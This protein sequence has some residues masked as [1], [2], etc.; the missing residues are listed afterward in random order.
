MNGRFYRSDTLSGSPDVVLIDA[1]SRA[2]SGPTIFAMRSLSERGVITLIVCNEIGK[3]KH[4]ASL[5]SCFDDMDAWIEKSNLADPLYAEH[6]D[7]VAAS[8]LPFFPRPAAAV[9]ETGREAA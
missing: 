7:D 6:K 8:E 1:G 9:G 4:E 2:L 5:K 3:S